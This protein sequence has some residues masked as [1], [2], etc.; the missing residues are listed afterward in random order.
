[1]LLCLSF[2]TVVSRTLIELVDISCV[3]SIEGAALFRTWSMNFVKESMSPFHI[4][5]MSSVNPAYPDYNVG[6]LCFVHKV[7]FESSHINI[8][9]VGCNSASHCCSLDLDELFVIESEV[10]QS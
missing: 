5:K 7:S 10:V 6:P 4:K 9:E 2:R 3:N 8:C 1:M